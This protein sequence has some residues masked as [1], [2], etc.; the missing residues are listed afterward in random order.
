MHAVCHIKQYFTV[1]FHEECI[2]VDV[3]DNVTALKIH[4]Y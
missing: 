3:T 2:S 4:W 1:L